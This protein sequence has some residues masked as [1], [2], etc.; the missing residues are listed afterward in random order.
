MKYVEIVAV[1]FSIISV[2]LAS[3]KNIHTWTT[4]IV[5]IVSYMFIFWSEKLYADFALQF[6]FILQSA[7][8]Y[9]AWKKS[10]EIDLRTVHPVDLA[11]ITL[12]LFVALIFIFRCY[13]DNPFPVLDS[14]A[15]TLSILAVWLMSQKML[16][17]W[18][19]WMA[20][21]IVYVILFFQTGLLLSC[22]LYVVFFFLAWK[23]YNSW[24]NEKV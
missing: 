5:G 11:A 2:V 10:K 14:L 20:A 17:A 12:S 23:G 19:V 13:T 7:W 24:K 1:I 22:S 4:G 15:S 9:S 8:G 6:V 16:F 3:R 18:R 21:N